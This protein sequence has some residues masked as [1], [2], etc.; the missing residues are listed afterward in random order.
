MFYISKP[1]FIHTI[2]PGAHMI[3]HHADAAV[4]CTVQIPEDSSCVTLA[5]D[6]RSNAPHSCL[7]T[8]TVFCTVLVWCGWCGS[9]VG[10]VGGV[11]SVGGVGG[12][13]GL[14]G[15][16]L[17]WSWLCLT[18]SWAATHYCSTVAIKNLTSFW[19]QQHIVQRKVT[20]IIASK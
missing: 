16:V 20:A 10:G 15:V 14:G 8:P 7:V 1:F 11:G 17:V 9:G 12:V 2:A 5:L 3:I 13:G 6:S 19:S 4:M 18:L